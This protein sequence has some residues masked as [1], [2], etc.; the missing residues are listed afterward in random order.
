MRLFSKR[1]KSNEWHKTFVIFPKR[2]FTVLNDG[3]TRW[4]DESY[5]CLCFME[6]R[7]SIVKGV[8]SGVEYR[9][10]AGV[11]VDHTLCVTHCGTDGCPAPLGDLSIAAIKIGN[12]RTIKP[13]VSISSNTVTLSELM[14]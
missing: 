13:A 14:Q 11:K 1:H 10:I 12:I 8:F 5:H 4:L 3:K 7:F 6:R 2:V 9:A